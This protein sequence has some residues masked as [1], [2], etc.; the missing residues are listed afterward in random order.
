M[1]NLN[2][3]SS[4]FPLSPKLMVK[5][6]KLA[7]WRLSPSSIEFPKDSRESNGGYATVLRAFLTYTQ[8]TVKGASNLSGSENKVADLDRQ[9]LKSDDRVLDAE[10]RKPVAVKKM[11]ISGD[12]IERILGLT[13]READF[14]AELAN[15]NVISFEG[16]VEDLSNNI[17]WLV[18]P[19][20]DNG[21]LRDFVASADWAIPERIW[22]VNILVNSEY[23]A[24]ITDFGSARRL[25]A[26]DVDQEEQG[27]G[28]NR[29]DA[30]TFSATLCT[31]TNTIT[32][33]GDRYTLRWAA[34]ELLEE[35]P[36]SLQSDIW[37]LGWVA[38]EVMTNS[39]PFQGVAEAMVMRRVI[40]G[41]LP[42]I[43]DDARIMLIKILYSFMM[44]CWSLDPS[45][46]PTAKD[47][48]DEFQ[49]MP[50]ASPRPPLTNDPMSVKIETA[51]IL[52]Q[53]GNM[54]RLRND[55]V[56]A[57]K[58]YTEAIRLF[59]ET[60]DSQRK[61][62]NLLGLGHTY[63]L[64]SECS[65]AVKL[66]SEALEIFTD[67][68]DGE[69]KADALVNL[70]HVHMLR[71]EYDQAAIF[72]T[73]A[74][75][76]QT[77]LGRRHGMA[78]ALSGLAGVHRF[79]YQ[80][81]QAFTCYSKAI[82]IRTDLG[83]RHGKADALRGLAEVH[84]F[85]KEYGKAIKVYS[86]SLEIRTEFGDRGGRADCLWGLAEVHYAQ[87]ESEKAIELYSEAL[88]IRSDIGDRHE[89]A[90]AMRG[91]AR[92]HR[93]QG[94]YSEAVK[95]F[96]EALQICT[97]I[98]NKYGRAWAILGIA[99]VRCDQN[100]YSNSLLHYEQAA[101]E[102]EQIRQGDIVAYALKR[103]AGVRALLEQK[104]AHAVSPR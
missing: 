62:H 87:G 96:S 3:S 53:L 104:E 64:Q 99:E 80:H 76:I 75:E 10:G 85:L 61:A 8:D 55:Y 68:G 88:K 103:A 60:A 48:R 89:E 98:D 32:L 84:R 97:D 44:R 39:M 24:I 21:N 30:P 42:P 66:Y 45:K 20:E 18:F 101:E 26:K 38:Y 23:R 13:L 4:R 73:E 77:S 28:R 63:R 82:E 35:Y 70:A 29:L 67:I 51:D 47:C 93:G 37:A 92:V 14:L 71:D 7:K 27:T 78:D 12:T 94:N 11:L 95:L 31:S 40:R 91:L 1:A 41:D 17:I 69:G 33:T 59:T 58:L 57:S 54:H 72:Y 100:D 22:L 52:Q 50:C 81:D 36:S 49:W 19:W 102:F 2:T 86:E 90:A 43:A 34:P 16:F 79:R 6:E 5:L 56:N 46:R 9:G 15:E 83:D 25:A 74:L 65:E